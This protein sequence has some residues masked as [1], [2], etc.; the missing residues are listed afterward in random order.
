M[1]SL[2]TLHPQLV[3][4]ARWLYDVGKYNDPRLVVTSSRRSIGKQTRLYAAWRR[5]ESRIPA[6]RPGT[7][8]HEHG[9]AFDMARLGIDPL[10]DP[11]LT[12]LGSIWTQIGGQWGGARDPVH[13]QVRV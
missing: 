8:L 3:Y 7:S 10:S 13:F 4:P 12:W 9:L 11:L 6:N 5:G 2:K 1:A